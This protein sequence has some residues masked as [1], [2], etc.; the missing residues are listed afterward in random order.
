MV[1][2]YSSFDIMV[3]NYMKSGPRT[4]QYAYQR[5]LDGYKRREGPSQLTTRK[6][7]FR[8]SSVYKT[9]VQDLLNAMDVL[10]LNL[11]S[12]SKLWKKPSPEMF[13]KIRHVSPK[14]K[15]FDILSA[16]AEFSGF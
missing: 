12:S 7:Y 10:Y 5:K 3:S 11:I 13:V 16:Q 14:R 15:R 8:G 2:F 6:P 4:I 9:G 1:K